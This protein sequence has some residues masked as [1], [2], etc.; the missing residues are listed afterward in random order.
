MDNPFLV[1]LIELSS[2]IQHNRTLEDGLRELAAMA[3]KSLGATRCSVM[4]LT[5]EDEE[6]KLRVYSHFGDLPEDAYSRATPLDRG[7][8][9]HVAS[10]GETLLVADLAAS[11]FAAHA[12]TAPPTEGSLMSAPIKIGVTVIGVI[13]VNR[14]CDAPNFSEA[15]KVLLDVL[16][17]FVGKSIQVFQL[18]NLA[19]SRVLQM[20]EILSRRDRNGDGREPICPDPARLAKMVAKNFFRELTAAGFGPSAIISVSSQVLSELNDS[21]NRHESRLI[22]ETGESGSR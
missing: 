2:K 1:R 12:R 3:A 5:E 13:N 17:L 10:T 22:R 19:E 7:I 6:R 8:A 14:L 4:L 15:D 11:E 20:A 16:S 9:G 18:Q 21:L